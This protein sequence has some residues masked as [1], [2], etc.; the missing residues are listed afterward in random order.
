MQCAMYTPNFFW[1]PA[2]ANGA[3]A[4]HD[5]AIR[6]AAIEQA[7]KETAWTRAQGGKE[8]MTVNERR[9]L[10]DLPEVDGG[11]V[12]FAS[13]SDIPLDM[14]GES[15]TDDEKTAFRKRLLQE[16]Y[17]KDKVERLVKAFSVKALQ[18]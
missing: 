6:R 17:P 10:V 7:K 13:I 1:N 12:I 8:F 2:Y 3:L 16:G 18:N 15:L 14:A 5:P 4:S 9:A 11:N